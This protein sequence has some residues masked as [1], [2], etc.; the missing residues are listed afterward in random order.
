MRVHATQLKGEKIQGSLPP[1]RA[2]P[3]HPATALSLFF[4]SLLPSVGVP[5][6]PGRGAKDRRRA[7][8]AQERIR[9]RAAKRR[10]VP[11][12]TADTPAHPSASRASTRHPPSRETHTRPPE[13]EAAER[14]DGPEFTSR[15]RRRRRDRRRR[16]PPPP[17]PPPASPPS[18]PRRRQ[19]Q[20]PWG[21]PRRSWPRWRGSPRRP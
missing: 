13:E 10:E 18:W 8:R 16:R 3:A 4:L 5:G 19:R 11:P 12:P 20:P 14:A 6:S 7:A 1:T 15:R 2:A 9:G 17:P 21:R